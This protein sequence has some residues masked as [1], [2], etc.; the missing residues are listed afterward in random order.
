M[1]HLQV[2]PLKKIFDNEA[3]RVF[4]GSKLPDGTKAV[5]IKR[6]LKNY[7][8]ILYIIHQRKYSLVNL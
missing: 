4:T 3:V 5:I 8:I 6:I 7:K 2:S 1:K